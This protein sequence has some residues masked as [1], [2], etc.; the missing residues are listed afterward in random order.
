MSS[1]LLGDCGSSVII[2]TSTISGFIVRITAAIFNIML[3]ITAGSALPCVRLIAESAAEAAMQSAG[4]AIL[5]L[6]VRYRYIAS[7]EA[8]A[9]TLS[10]Y[11]SIRAVVPIPSAA[12]ITAV[13]AY[14]MMA[15][16]NL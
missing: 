7:T 2:S 6:P 11:D 10:V 14:R 4:L 8:A 5:S 12:S 16:E 13:T 1:L 15:N 3:V 9:A